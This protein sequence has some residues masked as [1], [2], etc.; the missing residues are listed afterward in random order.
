MI[1]AHYPDTF[2][3][4]S[5]SVVILT[6]NGSRFIGNLLDSLADQSYPADK[7]EILIID[8]ASTD[9]TCAIVKQKGSHFTLVR[10]ENNLGFAAGN[11]IIGLS[12]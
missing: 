6:Y 5:V 3:W 9:D 12:I 10:L 4:P 7:I 8:N 2:D 1:M 11:N